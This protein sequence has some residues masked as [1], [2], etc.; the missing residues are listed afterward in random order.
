MNVYIL[1]LIVL[2]ALIIGIALGLLLAKK[3]NVKE[4]L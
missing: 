3:P 2:C 1:S 4:L